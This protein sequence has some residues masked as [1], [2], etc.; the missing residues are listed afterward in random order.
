MQ[1]LF[2]VLGNRKLVSI[3]KRR[4]GGGWEGMASGL[5]R[6]KALAL[7]DQTDVEGG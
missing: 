1:E 5:R 7:A 3:P 6:A 2:S 4:F